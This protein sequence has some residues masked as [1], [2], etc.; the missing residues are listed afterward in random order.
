L[1]CKNPRKI[2]YSGVEDVPAEQAWA[3]LTA[4]V[5][6]RDLD[7]VKEAA[8]R[9]FKACPEATYIDMEKAFRNQDI[10]VYLIAIEKELAVTYTNMDLQGNLDKK[11]SINW[12]FSDKP[13]RPKENE[14]W[15]STPE[16]NL[17]RLADAGVPVD[18][19]VPKWSVALLSAVVIP[20]A[21]FSKVRIVTN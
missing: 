6:D 11:F 9:Y 16:E 2:D 13:A 14:L 17:E 8:Q 3:Q 20:F 7:D 4:A 5:E 21:N 12:R 15:P 19:G 10:K 1:E 18:R